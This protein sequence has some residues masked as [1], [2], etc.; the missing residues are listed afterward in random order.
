MGGR[1]AARMPAAPDP[2]QSTAR[3]AALNGSVARTCQG[4]KS[5]RPSYERDTRCT[6]PRWD[7]HGQI[8][9]S[10]RDVYSALTNC[11]VLSGLWLVI[12]GWFLLE[13]ARSSY[14]QMEIAE[15][16]RGVRVGDVSRA[17]YDNVTWIRRWPQS[18][19]ECPTLWKRSSTPRPSSPASR[20]QRSRRASYRPGR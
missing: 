11:R 6:P 10:S 8:M 9:T 20:A 5:L 18:L 3:E 17:R 19:C 4:R 12:I 14:A 16:L 1:L 2:V 15:N 7:A 13:A